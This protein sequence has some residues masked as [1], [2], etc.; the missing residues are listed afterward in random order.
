MCFFQTFILSLH[1][2]TA[3]IGRMLTMLYSEWPHRHCGG[4]LIR[5]S[6]IAFR[7][8]HSRCVTAQLHVQVAVRKS[9]PVMGGG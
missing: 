9:C 6:L 4:L 7:L 8:L 5:R 3:N 1:N 2:K